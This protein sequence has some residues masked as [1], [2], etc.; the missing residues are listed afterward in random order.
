[1]L[2][3][4]GMN[5]GR[6]KAD[7]LSERSFIRLSVFVSFSI[8]LD[9][10]SIFAINYRFTIGNFLCEVICKLY[11]FSIVAVAWLASLFAVA[12]IRYSFKRVWLYSSIVPVFIHIICLLFLP[13]SYYAEDGA[14]Y[15]Y[16]PSVIA[17]YIFG[18]IYLAA[19]MTV[20]V[21]L[22]DQITMRRRFAVGFW[23]SCWLVTAGI[24][25]VNNKML[26]VSFA[27]SVACVYMYIKLENPEYLLDGLT[28]TFNKTGFYMLL[29]ENMS[30][31]ERRSLVVFSI[32]NMAKINEAF[33]LREQEKLLN[34]ISKYVDNLGELELF[35][36]EDSI[37]CASFKHMSDAENA[38]DQIVRRFSLPWDIDGER[39]DVDT[40]LVFISDTSSFE[41]VES[42]D[43]IIHY[44]IRESVLRG[45]GHVLY[46]NDEELSSR[47][48]SMEV[49]KMLE[50][51]FENDGIEV[52]YQP[53]YDIKNGKFTSME[54]LVRA[55]TADG[56]Q[57]PPGEFIEYAERNGMILRLG[58]IVFRK[59]CEFIQRSHIDNYGVEYIEVNLSVVQCMQE[60]LA[61]DLQD[62]MGEYN[63]P[64]YRIN[65]EITESAAA[66][67]KSLLEMNM[68]ELIAYGSDFSLDDYGSGY[69]NLSNVVGLPLKIIKID[70]TMVDDFF[71]S[72]KV[73]IATKSTI[74]MIHKLGMEIVVE[75][76][77]TE[78]QYLEFKK[79]NVEYIQGYYFSKPLPR[80]QV[81]TFIREWM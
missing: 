65:F 63:V 36:L 26:I 55:R 3:L 9:I 76:V 22:K 2:I 54:A 57:V 13:I 6:R 64:P 11:L 67:S 35:R 39:V 23:I 34:N 52:Y 40:S 62:I 31:K 43:E 12:E 7:F 20:V 81:V 14:V 79:L 59:V 30:F 73:K 47:Q 48:K 27:M 4:F 15:T 71:K 69:S 17:T 60:S 8:I 38:I 50:W 10:V 32:S 44:F 61:R 77:E 51:A 45:T 19:T 68:T 33:G 75:G 72:E 18:I 46:V 28:N 78:S 5:I 70:K 80:D 41:S 74:D 24:Q 25:Y 49:R 66:N 42:L 56:T 29:N 1:M 58:T 21:V 53:I 37:F 16:G